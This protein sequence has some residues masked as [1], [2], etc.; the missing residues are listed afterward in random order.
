MFSLENVHVLRY[1]IFFFF[2]ILYFQSNA[3]VVMVK[4]N[5]HLVII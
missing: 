1:Y 4:G 3:E 2:K 5:K